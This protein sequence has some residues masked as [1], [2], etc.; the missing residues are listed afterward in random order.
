MYKPN[1]IWKVRRRCFGAIAGFFSRYKSLVGHVCGPPHP[2]TTNSSPAL[3]T[4]A[5]VTDSTLAQLPSNLQTSK[6]SFCASQR[7][8]NN[9]QLCCCNHNNTQSGDCTK[10]KQKLKLKHLIQS[11]RV[12]LRNHMWRNRQKYTEENLKVLHYLEI[13]YIK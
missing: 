7:V 4:K 8:Q 10:T 3:Q 5:L 6:P 2:S 11:T 13:I 1:P 9:S 12:I